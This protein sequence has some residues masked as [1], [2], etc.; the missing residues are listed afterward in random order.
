MDISGAIHSLAGHSGAADELVRLTAKYGIALGV[1]IAL[2]L[3][4]RPTGVRS[5]AALGLGALLALVAGSVISNFWF[6]T[7]PF[8]VGHYAPLISHAGDASFPSDH[9]IV[10]GALVGS[11]WLGW[12]PLAWAAIALSLAIAFARVFAGVHYAGDVV[13]GF[14]L[15]AAA[16]AAVWYALSPSARML[17]HLGDALAD[18]HLRP[19]R[20]RTPDVR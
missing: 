11:T 10:M 19:A 6:E 20:P 4:F 13:A 2:A 17:A 18:M 15:G 14:L 1:V 3:W 12:R 16:A 7:R 9:L 5:I 8:I